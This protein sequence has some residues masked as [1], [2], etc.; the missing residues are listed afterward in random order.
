MQGMVVVSSQAVDT[1]SQRYSVLLQQ[2][3]D[4]ID[5]LR[6]ENAM[7]AGKLHASEDQV[8]AGAARISSLTTALTNLSWDAMRLST[9]KN[10]LI[11]YAYDKEDEIENLEK[12]KAISAA[13]YRKLVNVLLLQPTSTIRR[14][15][16]AGIVDDLV[17]VGGKSVLGIQ[18]I[19]LSA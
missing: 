14:A 17:A 3:H 19:K 7:L 16:D 5:Q 4:T 10:S 9:L 11:T 2:A 8:A 15:V 6:G 12:E 1:V 13:A 18:A